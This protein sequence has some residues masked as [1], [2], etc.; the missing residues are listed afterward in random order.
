[1]VFSS[2]LIH[3]IPQS[4]TST[5][6]R[7]PIPAISHLDL[8]GLRPENNENSWKACVKRM[9]EFLS[10]KKKVVLFAYAV[11]KNSFWKSSTPYLCFVLISKKQSQVQV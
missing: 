10:F 3:S 8:F 1:M 5:P 7:D 4:A 6:F 9:T 11:Y 2:R